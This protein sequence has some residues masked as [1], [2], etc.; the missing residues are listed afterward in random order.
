MDSNSTWPQHK[1][2][3][4]IIYWIFTTELTS[5]LFSN[6]RTISSGRLSGVRERPRTEKDV[7]KY[8]L[9]DHN[10]ATETQTNLAKKNN[11]VCTD[12]SKRW[13]ESSMQSHAG[14]HAAGFP[15]NPS[16]V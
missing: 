1:K 4:Y 9:S 13:R 6:D 7:T 16:Y 11:C 15:V 14:S 2:I 5:G 3:N 10:Q 8:R 12:N